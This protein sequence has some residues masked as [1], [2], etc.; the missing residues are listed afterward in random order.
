MKADISALNRKGYQKPCTFRSKELIRGYKVLDGRKTILDARFYSP[1]QGSSLYC[2]L[3]IRIPDTYTLG[4]GYTGPYGTLGT[5]L[6]LALKNLNIRL[7]TR[8][9]GHDTEPI[10]EVLEAIA[11]ALGTVEPLVV[12]FF[13]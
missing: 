10:P 12:D 8:I 13:A 11:I 5:A 2:A 1:R 9:D 6:A 4:V 7:D 3:W